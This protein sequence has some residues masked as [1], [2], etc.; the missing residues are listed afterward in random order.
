MYNQVVLLF[1]LHSAAVICPFGDTTTNR[2]EFAKVDDYVEFTPASAIFALD[3]VNGTSSLIQC[4]TQCIF[5]PLCLT[6]TLYEDL[7]LCRLFSADT[8]RGTIT[9]KSYA[10]VI[11]LIDRGKE[12]PKNTVP[13]DRKNRAFWSKG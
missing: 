13:L 3:D 11:S 7:R 9:G 12:Q 1:L 6:A 2:G 10:K 4:Y 8:S 5:N